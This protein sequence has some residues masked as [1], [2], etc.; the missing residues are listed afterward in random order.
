MSESTAA[1]ILIVEDDPGMVVLATDCLRTVEGW[2]ITAAVSAAECRAR[3]LAQPFD[4]ILLD[5]ACRTVT[6]P[7]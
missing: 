3:V 5:R 6:A 1:R 4:V 7:C 2:Q